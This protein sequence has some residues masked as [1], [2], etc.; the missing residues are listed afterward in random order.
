MLEDYTDILLNSRLFNGID[1]DELLTVLFCM[2]VSDVSYRKDSAV[3]TGGT[4]P[5]SVG[6]VLKGSLSAKNAS[7]AAEYPQGALF[8]IKDILSG[9]EFCSESV[10]AAED[11][12]VL[13]VTM[14]RLN[15]I[16][17]NRCGSHI[18]IIDNLKEILRNTQKDIQ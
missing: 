8:G 11:S 3:L 12:V 9:S 13:S 16:C 7:D 5:A 10:I 15:F 6:I 4:S 2:S 17:R 18:R 14:K 1:E